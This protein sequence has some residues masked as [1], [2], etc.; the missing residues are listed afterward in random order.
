M[1]LSKTVSEPIPSNSA[2]CRCHV[3]ALIGSVVVWF[4]R[5]RTLVQRGL[6]QRFVLL[7]HSTDRIKPTCTNYL[8]LPQENH[9]ESRLP[10][11]SP[12][13]APTTLLKIDRILSAIFEAIT[14]AIQV[15]LPAQPHKSYESLKNH[16]PPRPYPTKTRRHSSPT[17]KYMLDKMVKAAK[18]YT[19]ISQSLHHPDYHVKAH[20]KDFSIDREKTPKTSWLPHAVEDGMVYVSLQFW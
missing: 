19:F 5:T 15:Q 12:I 14:M 8:Q 1:H 18:R 11:L 6:N 10:N 9:T 17:L 20:Q 13:S 4:A 2:D 7:L 16:R 3:R